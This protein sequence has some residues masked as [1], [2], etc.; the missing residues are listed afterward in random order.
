M[1]IEDARPGTRIIERHV[2]AHPR[3]VVSWE[4]DGFGNTVVVVKNDNGRTS[5][6]KAKNI[7]RYDRAGAR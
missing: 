5:R 6:I 4:N 7:S 3:T 2:T 1:K